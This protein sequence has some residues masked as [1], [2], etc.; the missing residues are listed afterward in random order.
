MVMAMSLFRNLEVHCEEGAALYRKIAD[1][2]A[3]TH[4]EVV[5]DPYPG[6]VARECSRE[7]HLIAN[8]LPLF[9][10]LGAL[11]R[12]SVSK[13]ASLMRLP[14]TLSSPQERLVGERVVVKEIAIIGDLRPQHLFRMVAI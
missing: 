7:F 5:Y 6:M 1:D 3:A 14:L 4:P 8:V 2:L 12:S 11:K 10:H 13:E 9:R